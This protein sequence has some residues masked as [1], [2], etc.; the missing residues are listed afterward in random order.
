MACTGCGTPY[1]TSSDEDK[2]RFLQVLTLLIDADDVIPMKKS[3]TFGEWSKSS[4][5]NGTLGKLIKFV[6]LPETDEMRKTMAT[7]YDKRG[8]SLM[9][10]LIFVAWS[11]EEFHPKERNSSS[12]AVT[13]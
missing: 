8:Y 2:F 13:F 3:N 1:G 5:E 12:T 9:M 4:V 6:Q 10:D 7:F 11:D